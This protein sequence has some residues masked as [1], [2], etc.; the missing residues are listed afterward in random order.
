LTKINIFNSHGEKKLL[1]KC[2]FIFLSFYRNIFLSQYLFIAM[3]FYRNI[4][5]LCAEM[6]RV[7]NALV[8]VKQVANKS[9]MS[10][11]YLEPLLPAKDSTDYNKYRDRLRETE[12]RP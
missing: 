6:S 12:A 9:S 7:N 4:A 5:I 8:D 3:S 10:A 2:L 11:L 1:Q